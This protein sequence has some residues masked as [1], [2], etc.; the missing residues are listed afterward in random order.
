MIDQRLPSTNEV[1]G[2][3][4]N[5]GEHVTSLSKGDR[6]AGTNVTWYLIIIEL[7]SMSLLN[8]KIY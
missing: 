5:V 7:I 2:V 1:S 4:V 8:R 3:V 6:V